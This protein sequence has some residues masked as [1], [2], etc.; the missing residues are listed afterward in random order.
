MPDRPRLALVNDAPKAGRLYPVGKTQWVCRV[1]EHDIGVATSE[2]IETV[3]APKID[4]RG[5][6][7]GTRRFICLHCHRRGKTTEVV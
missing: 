5:K 6:V 3:T 7:S 4:A 2:V 1:C